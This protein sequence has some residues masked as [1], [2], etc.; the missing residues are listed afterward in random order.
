[1]EFLSKRKRT[2]CGAGDNKG[3][4]TRAAKLACLK[5]SDYKSYKCLSRISEQVQTEEEA[6]AHISDQLNN[7]DAL[8]KA[9]SK[10]IEKFAMLDMLARH[11]LLILRRPGD[12]KSSAIPGAGID[13]YTYERRY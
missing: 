10:N 13:L 4:I 5:D 7:S 11:N 3:L 1:M 8:G 9:S 6:L 12:K 2:R